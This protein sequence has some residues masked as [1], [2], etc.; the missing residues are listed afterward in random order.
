MYLK[1]SGFS[2]VL[3]LP[4]SSLLVRVDKSLDRAVIGSLYIVREKTGG[5]LSRPPM[6][7]N[8]FTADSL[9]TAG[10]ITAVA[11]FL[12]LLYTAFSHSL[13]SLFLFS[14]RLHPS[15]RSFVLFI[16]PGVQRH[17]LFS[18]IPGVLK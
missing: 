6:I 15:P 11:S 18:S 12:I 4:P 14:E 2:Y 10:L 16:P 13:S 9:P 5:Q 17:I 7:G 1:S 3:A 8:T